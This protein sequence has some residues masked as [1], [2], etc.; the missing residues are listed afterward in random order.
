MYIY[1]NKK[2]DEYFLFGNMSV[3]ASTTGISHNTLRTKFSR[4]DTKVQG[5]RWETK[6]FTIVKT[7]PIKS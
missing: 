2:I 3:M 5:G 6:D 4:S 7:K 1:H